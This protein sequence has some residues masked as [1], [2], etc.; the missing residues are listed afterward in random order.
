MEIT[1]DNSL[2]GKKKEKKSSERENKPSPLLST[3]AQVSKYL[4]LK[5]FGHL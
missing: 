5:V 4:H 3:D 1:V 2:Q